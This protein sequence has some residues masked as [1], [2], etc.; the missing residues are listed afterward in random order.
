MIMPEF[1]R[2][3]HKFLCYLFPHKNYSGKKIT[4]IK[5]IRTFTHLGPWTAIL[6]C[7]ALLLWHGFSSRPE[8]TIFMTFLGFLCIWTFVFLVLSR[9]LY[10][11]E[12]SPA[13]TLML[14]NWFPLMGILA[15]LF[16]LF[17]QKSMHDFR[18]ANFHISKQV[19]SKFQTQRTF[20]NQKSQEME[21][22]ITEHIQNTREKLQSMNK[23]FDTNFDKIRENYM[24]YWEQDWENMSLRFAEAKKEFEAGMIKS[25]QESILNEKQEFTLFGTKPSLVKKEETPE[26]EIKYMNPPDLFEAL[27]YL[28]NKS[29]NKRKNAE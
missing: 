14:A 11:K 15:S 20:L 7:L 28:D 1:L 24:K 21:K 23:T 2:S 13:V 17:M 26:K 4:D 29:K 3:I 9:K 22:E 18:K 16:S 10:Q 27:K 6:G 19:E 25:A 12:R 5:L 8:K